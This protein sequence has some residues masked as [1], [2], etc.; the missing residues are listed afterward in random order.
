[1][2]GIVKDSAKITLDDVAA[3]AGVSRATADRVVNRRGNVKKATIDKVMDAIRLV[4]Y[5]PDVYA[6][7]FSRKSYLH[8]DFIFP[9]ATGKYFGGFSASL[10]QNQKIFDK[11]KVRYR[12]HFVDP[13]SVKATAE[14]LME[15][16][17][18]SDGIALVAVDHP[19]VRETLRT[20]QRNG[21][22]CV[23][24]VT[25]VIHSDRLAYVGID[26]R[27][28]GRT[29]GLL[30]ARFL[31]ANQTGA[32]GLLVGS[33]AYRGHEEREMGFR[34]KLQESRPDLSIIALNEGLDDDVRSYEIVKSAI[35]DMPNLIG[36]YN[37]GAGTLGVSKAL[38]EANLSKSI[39]FIAHEFFEYTRQ[40]LAS[41]VIDAIINQNIDHEVMMAVQ[42]LMNHCN[43]QD[44]MWNVDMPKVEIYLEENL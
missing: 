8:F 36:I 10:Q 6:Q 18:S 22:P 44:I 30:M 3:R 16:S 5:S 9:S 4:E 42:I 33:H 27:A 13:M 7:G 17:R 28:A 41:G 15:V 40:Y 39:T 38:I 23:T 20:V 2:E 29:A 34:G 32:I 25:D 19:V 37:V 14:K 11:L 12:V 26:N 1:V 35:H 31:D 24:L 43:N 21:V